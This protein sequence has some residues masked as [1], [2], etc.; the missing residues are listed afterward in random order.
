MPKRLT[1]ALVRSAGPGKY[2]DEHGLFLRVH[3]GGSRQWMQRIVSSR[4][5][6]GPGLGWLAG[7]LA[8]R[9]PPVRVREPED[10]AVLVAI[11][12][13]RS[14]VSIF[15]HSRKRPSG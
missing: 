15:R 13:L 12:W 14:V 1:V 2:Y 11:L 3:P 4:Q 6:D 10:G 5:A 7:G 8:G 9:S